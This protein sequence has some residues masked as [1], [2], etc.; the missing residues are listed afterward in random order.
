MAIQQARDSVNAAA[1]VTVPR[2]SG[3]FKTGLRA[4]AGYRGPLDGIALDSEGS[5]VASA[6][7]TTLRRRGR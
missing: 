1:N 6:S 4:G 3:Q 5:R 2:E 7:M